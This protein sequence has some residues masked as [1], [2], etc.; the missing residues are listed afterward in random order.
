MHLTVNRINNKPSPNLISFKTKPI[1]KNV[2]INNPEL[3]TSSS[4]IMTNG[5]AKIVIDEKNNIHKL[6]THIKEILIAK[7][8][9]KDKVDFYIN[10][11]KKNYETDDFNINALKFLEKWS[12]NFEELK[13][14]DDFDNVI[15]QCC[16]INDE[17]IDSAVNLMKDSVDDK[18]LF[19][20]RLMSLDS[21]Y[22]AD[23]SK[24]PREF[25]ENFAKNP[26]YFDSSYNCENGRAIIDI[27]R[28][29]IENSKEDVQ[30]FL[31]LIVKDSNMP[32]DI[33]I[34]FIERAQ[35]FAGDFEN[36]A[37]LLE[38]KDY[39]NELITYK[40]DVVSNSYS[41]DK[42]NIDELDKK[43]AK[44][45]N[46]IAN[47]IRKHPDLYTNYNQVDEKKGKTAFV[48]ANTFLY[49]WGSNMV[50]LFDT[51]DDQTIDYIMRLRID[52]AIETMKEYL[53]M[54]SNKLLIDLIKEFQN[55]TTTENKP[56]TP[57]QKVDSIR[58]VKL[59]ND[60]IMLP[61]S[62]LQEILKKGKINYWEIFEPV[63]Y[64]LLQNTG[65]EH[66]EI[67]KIDLTKFEDFDLSKSHLLLETLRKDYS[68]ATSDV[69]WAMFNTNFDEFIHDE[70][71]EYDHIF[72]NIKTKDIF[73]ENN[74]NY[75]NW[76]HPD[77]NLTMNFVSGN[78]MNEQDLLK[79]VVK[80]IESNIESLRSTG[81]KSFIDKKLSEFMP[82]GKFEIPQKIR[83]DKVALEQFLNKILSELN[84][85]FTRAS[86]KV[87]KISD[88][89]NQEA[90]TSFYVSKDSSIKQSSPVALFT[91]TVFSHL[92]EALKT[93]QDMK[94]IKNSQKNANLDLT[95]KM[96]D[97]NPIKDIF[98]GNYSNCCI[99]MGDINGTSMARYLLNSAFNMIEIVDNESGETIGNSLCYFV[100]NENN[101]P[102]F[103]LDNIEINP[104]YKMAEDVEKE[105]RKSLIDYSKKIAKSVIGNDNFKIYLGTNYNDIDCSDLLEQETKVEFLG[106]ISTDSLYLDGYKGWINREDLNSD[107]FYYDVTGI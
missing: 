94:N 16:L 23:N 61:F 89:R 79:P 51:F 56:L 75:E 29:A 76:I 60:H 19:L 59:Y 99:A 72:S 77:K 78:V 86:K 36:I 84:P 88:V 55:V 37:A 13:D 5:L 20:R 22:Y 40:L 48:V 67:E 82:E 107:L 31:S 6:I 27:M 32:P 2:L 50:R 4:A 49:Q 44:R 96:W 63:Y 71:S 66:R 46:K 45:F 97:R 68:T 18:D 90:N 98:Q 33:G 21:Y 105:F 43:I 65:M 103:V 54:R 12:E 26:Q 9:E 1:N 15:E 42:V 74:Y 81:A 25:M 62:Y 87:E 53:P 80:S 106:D 57:K 30:K 102:V 70:T 35:T 17:Y 24:I 101:E 95:I 10:F 91:L 39:P 69:V 83:E 58:I 92:K 41:Q 104:N 14:I 64:T 8:V 11:C 47:H 7:G 34:Y 38:N 100:K 85:V 73:K 52:K 93:L 28:T 3:K